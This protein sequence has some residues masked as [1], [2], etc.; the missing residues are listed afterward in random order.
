MQSQMQGEQQGAAFRKPR[1]SFSNGN[2]VGVGGA[3]PAVLV[4]DTKQAGQPHRTVLAFAPA[5]WR[6]FTAGLR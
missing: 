1:R 4:R 6:A 3:A 5:A 2:C